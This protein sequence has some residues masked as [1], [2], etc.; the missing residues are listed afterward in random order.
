M[1]R[2]RMVSR[3]R[4]FAEQSRPAIDERH[5][6]QTFRMCRRGVNMNT[7]APYLAGGLIAIFSQGV[8]AI[9]ASQP[10]FLRND[11]VAAT[12]VSLDARAPAVSPQRARIGFVQDVNRIHK[13]DRL[14]PK[15]REVP[16]AANSGRH[17]A[18]PATAPTPSTA[19]PKL[20]EGCTSAVSILSDRIAANQ[21]SNCITALEVPFKVA[22]AD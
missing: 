20:P 19:T 5:F 4:L 14:V 12:F 10:T 17:P 3:A 13:G 16:V 11:P 22:V 2:E 21:A 9:A 1:L 7:L 6:A 18:K 8:L 15:H